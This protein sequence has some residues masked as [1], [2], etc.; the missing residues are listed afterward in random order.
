MKYQRFL[1]GTSL[2]VLVL[3]LSGIVFSR[4]HGSSLRATSARLASRVSA[5]GEPKPYEAHVFIPVKFDKQD[6][7]LSCEVATLK[8]VLSNK[9]IGGIAD[10][11]RIRC[12]HSWYAAH[13][14]IP[15][16]VGRLLDEHWRQGDN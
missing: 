14:V 16:T 6:H 9:G 15:N 13:L 5:Y 2:V 1:F 10:F 11:C 12:L 8:M 3:V 7:A 4:L